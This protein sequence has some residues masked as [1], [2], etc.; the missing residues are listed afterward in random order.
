MDVEREIRALANWPESGH[1]VLSVYLDASRT[2]EHA[3]QKLR[4]FIKDRVKQ[5]EKEMAGRR[6]RWAAVEEDVR[7]IER[8]VE[9]LLAGLHDSEYNGIALFCCEHEGLRSVIRSRI[10]F[11]NAFH[12]APRPRIR[13]LAH[14]YDEFET[15]LFVDAGQSHAAIYLVAAGEI[16]RVV[17]IENEITPR[18]KPGRL[19]PSGRGDDQAGAHYRQVSDHLVREADEAGVRNVLLSGTSQAVASLK[20]LL[21]KRLAEHV[22]AE[23]SLGKNPSREQVRESAVKALRE[24]ERAREEA[25]VRQVLEMK[26]QAARVAVG[27]DQV[28][29]ALAHGRVHRLLIS[30]R[31]VRAGFRCTSCGK[32]GEKPPESCELCGEPVVSTDL[33]EAMVV[34]AIQRGADIDEI[35]GHAEFEELGG[36][37]ALL[38]Y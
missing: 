36:V 29:R 16:D 11:P 13:P 7:F 9:G 28:L 10:A 32:L 12:V 38:R 19:P 26:T 1:L 27:V 18:P 15:A 34:S 17:T 37:A 8:Y 2:D 31:F 23:L 3:R 21:P 20:R 30:D 24:A 33:G 6:S 4:I 14:L 5:L 22:I 35:V 25:V